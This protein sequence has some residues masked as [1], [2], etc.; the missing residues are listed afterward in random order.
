MPYLR[1]CPFSVVVFI[2]TVV[3][4]TRQKRKQLRKDK[5]NKAGFQVVFVLGAPGVGMFEQ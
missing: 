1:V 4:V 3:V 5:E 2:A